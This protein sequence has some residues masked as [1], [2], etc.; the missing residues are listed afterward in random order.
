[1]LHGVD[2]SNNN[3]LVSIRDFKI[4][5]A[6]AKVSEGQKFLDPDFSAFWLMMKEDKILRGAYHFLDTSDPIAQ[7]HVF[8]SKVKADGLEAD[9]VLCADVEHANLTNGI[10]KKFVNEVARLTEKNVFIYCNYDFLHRG[11]VNGLYDHPFW[12]ANPGGPVGNP[13]D[14][15]PYRIWTMQQYD[16]KVVDKD[17]FN[18]TKEVWKGLANLHHKPKLMEY[19]SNGN[20]S[21]RQ[22]A[23]E[24]DTAPSTMLRL[25][26]ENSNKAHEF[27]ARQAE[28]INDV[29]SGRELWNAAVPKGIVL[30]YKK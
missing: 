14:V 26:A 17:V 28:F 21:F 4:D 12:I 15:H 24:L 20:L 9:D 30:Y 2:I 22:I 3:G 23:D 5:F 8:V 1:M 25:T 11:V 16:W 6:I 10:V 27:S 19:H 13:P 29:F 7:A 18:G